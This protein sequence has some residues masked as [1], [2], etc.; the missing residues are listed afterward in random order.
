MPLAFIGATSGVTSASLPAG[1]QP[2]DLAVVFAFRDGSTTPPSL[3]AGWTNIING[4]ANTCSQRVG[5]R[6]L[7]AGDSTTGTWT[8]ATTVLCCVYRGQDTT[9][10]IGASAQQGASSATVTYPGLTLQRTNGTSW[11]FCGAGHRSIDTALET[12]PTGTVLRQNNVDTTD[13]GSTFDTNGGVTSWSAQSVAVGGTASGWRAVSVELL[14]QPSVILAAAILQ[15]DATLRATAQRLRRGVT[16]LTAEATLRAAAQS[17]VRGV[18]ILTAEATLR[19]QALAVRAA[20]ALW[21]TEATLQSTVTRLVSAMAPLTAEA[22]LRGAVLRT[23]HAVGTLLATAT[24][25]AHARRSRTTAGQWTA[26]ATLHAGA[27]RTAAADTALVAEATLRGALTSSGSSAPPRRTALR[28]LRF[29][30]PARR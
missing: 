16:A 2:G 11:V 12:P 20:T 21:T 24:Q 26:D 29:G 4:G 22:S 18:T 13:E 7:Q 6:V 5:Y 10:P 27:A 3:P 1:W 30:F 9:T 19:A 25:G 28:R 8:N 23:A 14:A 15:A 17:L